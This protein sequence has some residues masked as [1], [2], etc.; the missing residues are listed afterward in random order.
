MNSI[1][2]IHTADLHLDSPFVGLRGLPKEIY[3]EVQKST[4]QSF[5]NIVTKAIEKKVDFIV[6][7]GDLFD[8]EDRSIRAQIL[9]RKEME[10]LRDFGIH[11]FIVHG[12]HD[13][14]SGSWTDI[15]MPENVHIF[16]EQVEMFPFITKKGV[17]VHLYGFSYPK[18]HMLEDM[19]KQYRKVDGA[20]FHIGILHGSDGSSQQHHSYAPFKVNDLL[21]KDFDYWALGH[22]HQTTLLHEEP[23]ILYPGNI[24]GRHKKENGEK[25]CYFVEL[26]PYGTITEWINTAPIEWHE[27]KIAVEEPLKTFDELYQTCLNIKEEFR[28]KGKGIFLGLAIEEEKLDESV[29]KWLYDED[30]LSLLKEGEERR[31]PFVWIY[32][33]KEIKKNQSSLPLKGTFLSELEELAENLELLEEALPP[34][35]DHPKTKKYFQPLTVEEKQEIRDEAMR[36]IAELLKG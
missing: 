17:K 36:I 34:L 33:V 5:S 35:F 29:K 10:R 30:F 21:K 25:G 8:L 2:F 15:S 18:R 24:Q 11:A 26:S 23:V 20:D 7:A 27:V 6:I 4:F 19:T 28:Q 22:I 3:Q 31:N 12:N 9:F 13:Y 16:P 32:D 1:T 14:L